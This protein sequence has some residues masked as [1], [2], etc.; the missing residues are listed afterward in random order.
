[1]STHA[2]RVKMTVTSVASSGTGDITLNAASTGYR[3]FAT[4]YG[5]NATVDILI[6]EGTAWEIARNCT[7]THSGT[8]VSRG[9]LESSSTGSAVVFTSAAVVSVIATAAF[10]NNAA[11]NHVAASPT[12]AGV[13][14][15][16]GTMHL[17]DI[18]GLTASRNF[19][20]PATAA[21][22][23]RVGV[24]LTTGDAS[25]ELIII[26]DTGD[27]INGGSANTEWSR[28]LI[29]NE[30]VILRCVTAN[31]AWVVEYDGRIPQQGACRLTTAA[32]GEAAGTV[33]TP[34]D[35]SGAWTAYIDNASITIVA[36]SDIKVRRAG[37]FLVSVQGVSNTNVTDGN[38]F[39]VYLYKNGNTDI[40]VGVQF[41]QGA[42]AYGRVGAQTSIVD[43]A[44]G[45]Y[46]RYRFRSQQGSMG[47]LTSASPATNTTFSLVEVL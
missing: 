6:T 22:G 14:G 44:A 3:S 39:S 8:T 38:Y 25:Y 37:N 46:I 45:D 17:L 24:Y 35:A 1:M 18:S 42:T 41:A 10:G 43:L 11:L 16:V 19:T 34:T 15:V 32:S 40:L 26:G 2:N 12:T 13:T 4:A 7:Y 47:L 21:V 28:L 36:S 27:T 30:C 23:D 5:A 29:T 31:S 20:L 9:T 33:T